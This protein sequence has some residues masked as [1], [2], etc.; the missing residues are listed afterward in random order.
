MS[1]KNINLVLVSLFILAC[2]CVQMR[3]YT[4]VRDGKFGLDIQKGF[5]EGTLKKD[6][7]LFKDGTSII[8]GD[9]KNEVSAKIGLP[10]KVDY[11]LEK[12]EIWVYEEKGMNLFFKGEKLGGWNFF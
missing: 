7:Y 12:E 10:D 4:G 5:G 8:L 6:Y 11:N 9:T 2:G 3:D 1:K